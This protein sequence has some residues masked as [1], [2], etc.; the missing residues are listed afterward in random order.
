MI[1]RIVRPDGEVRHLSSNGQ[2]IVGEDDVPIRMRGTCIDITD[3]VL[4]DRE[5]ERISARFMELVNSAPDA[6]LVLDGD[7]RIISANQMAHELLR[8]SR[9][10]PHPRRTSSPAGTVPTSTA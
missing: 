2:V 9:R 6:I 5:R 1:E 8:P 7:H 4:A 3:R 10:G